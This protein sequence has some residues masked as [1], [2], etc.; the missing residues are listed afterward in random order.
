MFHRTVLFHIRVLAHVIDSFPGAACSLRL[1]L[2][3]AEK[4]HTALPRQL[5][6][7]RPGSTHRAMPE[8]YPFKSKSPLTTENVK[9]RSSLR[10]II[11]EKPVIL[12]SH[13]VM[14]VKTAG[15]F[16]L[17]NSSQTLWRQLW[18]SSALSPF[19]RKPVVKSLRYL[20]ERATY[21]PCNVAVMMWEQAHQHPSVSDE[22][23]MR[24]GNERSAWRSSGLHM[25]ALIWT[26]LN[27]GPLCHRSRQGLWQWMERNVG[28][29]T[30]RS[31]ALSFRFQRSHH[32]RHPGQSG[33]S[34]VT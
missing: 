15:K 32:E 27:G 30:C 33:C 8:S 4:A 1:G 23:V 24:A 26:R 21:E 22:K 13:F 9:R 31:A 25:L 20:V 6:L 29:P 28:P 10:G 14:E 19:L 5:S 16:P 34:P 17:R 7:T 18:H 3:P 2:A 11:T 12:P